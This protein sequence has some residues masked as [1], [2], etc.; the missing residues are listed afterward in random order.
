MTAPRVGFKIGTEVASGVVT[1]EF[2][3]DLAD[4]RRLEATTVVEGVE[5]VTKVL[6]IEKVASVD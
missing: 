1:L 3:A 6:Q 2:K 5:G 4:A